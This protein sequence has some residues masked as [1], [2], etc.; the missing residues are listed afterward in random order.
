M[1]LKLLSAAALAVAGLA[2]AGHGAKADRIKNPIAVF[3]GLDKIT[4]RIVSFEAAVGET[5]Q[6]GALQLTPRACYTRPATETPNTTAFVIVDEVTTASNERKRIFSGWMYAASPG[7]HGIE[8]AVYDIWL[9]D[10]EGGTDVIVDPKEGDSEPPPPPATPD[11][12][13]PPPARR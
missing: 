5:V 6:F 2:A 7:L 12:R 4:G 3:S 1:N 13:R 10:C 8:H 9:T 11:P